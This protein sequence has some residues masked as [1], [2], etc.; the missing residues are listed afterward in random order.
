MR[1]F[2][3][4]VSCVGKTA[5]G[6][7]LAKL[8]SYR[9]FDFDE[10]VEKYYGIPIEHLQEKYL[11][12]DLFRQKASIALAHILS[13]KESINAV[14]ALPPSGLMRVYWEVVKESSGMII[15]IKDTAP[16]ILDRIKFY[17]KDSKPISTT[18]STKEKQYYLTDIKKDILYY[19]SSYKR[20]N[21]D[22]SIKGLNV[23]DAARKIQKV[24]FK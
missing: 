16:N 12:M 2:L 8:L 17:D 18:L 20:A 4:G 6:I 13:S 22:I 10:E 24:V 1:I 3:A 9:F 11:T 19:N 7:E 14:I 15:A 23:G 5:I 21:Y